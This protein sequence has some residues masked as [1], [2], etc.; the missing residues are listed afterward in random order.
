M[1]ELDD[2]HTLLSELTNEKEVLP[3]GVMT[4]LNEELYFAEIDTSGL[5]FLQRFPALLGLDLFQVRGHAL[6]EPPTTLLT[7]SHL[8]LEVGQTANT[9]LSEEE[10]YLFYVFRNSQ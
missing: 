1:S 5:V 9:V 2:Y 10:A 3:D 8:T 4:I 7:N 6:S